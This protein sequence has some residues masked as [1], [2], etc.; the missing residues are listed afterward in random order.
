MARRSTNV[1]EQLALD[2][3]L[4]HRSDFVRD[5]L[6]ESDLPV[7]GTKAELRERLEG[8]LGAGTIGIGD[9]IEHLDDIEGWGNQHVY[10]YQSP[11]GLLRTWRAE[12]S[13]KDILRRAKKISL[14]NAHLPL[15]LPAT[16]TLSRVAWSPQRVRFVWI[17]TR[18]WEE[19]VEKDDERDGARIWKAYNERSARGVLAFDW[20][21]LSGDAMLSIERLPSGNDY[22]DARASLAKELAHFVDLN[23]FTTVEVGRAIQPIEKSSEVL[24]RSLAL[25]SVRGTRVSFTSRSRKRDAFERD[26]DAQRSRE[27]LG[28]NVAGDT[29]NFYWKR[30]GP[31][32]DELHTTLYAKDGRVGIFGQRK[33]EEVTHVIQR[34]R[35]Y[36]A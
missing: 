23:V 14:M 13:V 4:D 26:P 36:C 31:L 2:L 12:Q 11:E 29:G 21:L 27:S 9:I 1:D 18:T 20:N 6:R 25:R 19:R 16:T 5:F 34:I 24:N 17:T 28:D 7:S 3:L 10:L 35:H 8:A 32:A 15:A 33:E 22:E 30:T